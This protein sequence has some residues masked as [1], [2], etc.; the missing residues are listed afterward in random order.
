VVLALVWARLTRPFGTQWAARRLARSG[1]LSLSRLAL[2]RPGQH[3]DEVASEV[4]DRTA[5]LLPRLGQLDDEGLALQDATR[6]LRICFRL[7]ELKQARLPTTIEQQLQPVLLAAHDYFKRCATQGHPEPAPESL[8]R[9]LDHSL[10]RLS[11]QPGQAAD[12]ACQALHG[13]RLALFDIAVAP[14]RPAAT[15]YVPLGASA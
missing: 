6:E 1:W 2:A 10:Q 12:E 14:P 13:L 8:Y 9:L 3:Y 15:E 4:I 11:L 7:L 5:Q